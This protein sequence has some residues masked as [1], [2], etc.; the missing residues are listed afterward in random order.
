MATLHRTWILP[1]PAD[2]ITPAVARRWLSRSYAPLA[3]LTSMAVFPDVAMRGI[4][5]RMLERDH[6]LSG[7][8]IIA[9]DVRRITEA[10][11]KALATGRAVPMEL[12]P[13]PFIGPR[14]SARSLRAVLKYERRR[15]QRGARAILRRALAVQERLAKAQPRVRAE[16]GGA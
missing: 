15:P 10:C 6:A 9:G 13:D 7:L 3:R 11:G 2:R 4:G 12:D 8:R 14:S 16:K 1:P 5:L